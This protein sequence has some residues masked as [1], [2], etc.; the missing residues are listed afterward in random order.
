MD[1][2]N[3][4]FDLTNENVPP[5]LR[6][7]FLKIKELT[8]LNITSS[9]ILSMGASLVDT[10]IKE[11]FLSLPFKLGN[12]L[13]MLSGVARNPDDINEFETIVL[14]FASKKISDALLKGDA[15]SDNILDNISENLPSDLQ[16]DFFKLLGGS[17]TIDDIKKRDIDKNDI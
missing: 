11:S 15:I 5:E 10:A 4:D 17:T 8:L 12:I 7:E 1:A 14:N 9:A 3:E 2:E 6:E 16:K 13:I